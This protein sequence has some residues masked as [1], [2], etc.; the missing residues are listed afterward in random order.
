MVNGFVMVGSLL[1]NKSPVSLSMVTPI[2][3]LTAEALVIVVP[4]RLEELVY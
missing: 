1:A 4:H 3:R 2:A